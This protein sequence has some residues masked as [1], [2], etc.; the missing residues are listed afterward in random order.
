MTIT[1]PVE[2]TQNAALS[3]QD[4]EGELLS[5]DV[6]RKR[7]DGSRT[8]TA[9][10]SMNTR[11]N[12]DE[13][14]EDLS[15]RD[16]KTLTL[17]ERKKLTW[18][19]S[20]FAVGC[21]H[22]S[23]KDDRSNC[24]R[25]SSRRGGGRNDDDEDYDSRV[26]CSAYVCGCLGARRVGNLAILAQTTEEYDHLEVINEETGEYR[27]TRRTRPKLLWVIGP[28]W[29]NLCILIVF[30]LGASVLMASPKNLAESTTVGLG[31]WSFVHLVMTF[32]LIMAGCRNPGVLYRHSHP[33]PNTDE[34]WTWNDQSMTYRPPTAK[35][36]PECQ[37]VIEDFEH[38]YVYTKMIS[39][40]APALGGP[41]PSEVSLGEEEEVQALDTSSRV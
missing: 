8:D 9:S 25:R 2:S 32:A 20:P 24:F 35:F 26:C 21:V 28:Y 16:P 38:T 17:D 14:E 13:K 1:V 36:D 33:P 6:E 12:D 39:F 19:T 23:W 41:S 34:V 18:E 40:F 31:M 22:A 30:L 27:T 11:D 29:Y 5:T 37:A 3:Q 4:R 15:L 7:S 10:D